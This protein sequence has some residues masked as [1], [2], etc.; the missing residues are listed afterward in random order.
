MSLSSSNQQIASSSEIFHHLLLQQHRLVYHSSL[1]SLIYRLTVSSTNITIILA[2]HPLH[3]NF[4][5]LSDNIAHHD[6]LGRFTLFSRM[7]THRD[8]RSYTPRR[9]TSSMPSGSVHRRKDGEGGWQVIHEHRHLQYVIP[10]ATL[11]FHQ[12]IN[13][14]QAGL[15][16]HSHRN[17][18]MHG[19][20]SLWSPTI[21]KPSV[22]TTVNSKKQLP[23]FLISV[24]RFC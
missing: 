16:V 2:Q 6:P 20:S 13:S 15:D 5:V 9:R 4:F 14:T 1:F 3:F 10:Y 7:P 23:V 19:Q 24:T 11:F 8:R 18:I 12:L 17:P 22:S 21:L